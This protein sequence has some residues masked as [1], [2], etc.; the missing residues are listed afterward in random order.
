VRKSEM[1]EKSKSFGPRLQSNF[2]PAKFFFCILE[3]GFFAEKNL[4][5]KEDHSKSFWDVKNSKYP[6]DISKSICK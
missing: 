5:C 4:L 1:A 6:N 2:F 3:K